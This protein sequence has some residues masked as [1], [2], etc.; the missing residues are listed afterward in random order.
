MLVY[1]DLLNILLNAV[2][3]YKKN[4]LKKIWHAFSQPP[5]LKL[6]NLEIEIQKHVTLLERQADWGHKEGEI[7]NLTIHTMIKPTKG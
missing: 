5:A 4:K 3:Y 7:F 2:D 6:A 1:A